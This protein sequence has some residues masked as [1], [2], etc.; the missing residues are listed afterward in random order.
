MQMGHVDNDGQKIYY[1]VAGAGEPLLLIMGLSGDILSWADQISSLKQHYTV[2]AM[3]NRDAGRSGAG[4]DG[5][6]ITDMASDCI[7]VL[8]KLGIETTHV[9]GFSMGGMIAQELVLTSPARV[10]KLIL[11]ATSARLAGPHASVFDA[12]EFLVHNDA[13]GLARIKFVLSM[14]MTETFLRDEGMVRQAIALSKA[15]PYPQSPQGFSRQA[16]A[17]RG[18]DRQERVADILKDTLV[19]IG[20]HDV[21]VPPWH[22]RQLANGIKNAKLQVIKQGG[23][24]MYLDCAD[25]FKQAV[26]EFLA[27]D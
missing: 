27:D 20:D 21:L 17:L 25:P 5:Y 10:R 6:G 16:S 11:Y 4:T 24:G 7:A 23:H 1:E 13:D 2:I 14:C 26:L 15:H 8:D 12:W 19:L 3:D 18:F 9:L 22:S